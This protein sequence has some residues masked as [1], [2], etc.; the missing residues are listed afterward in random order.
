MVCKNPLKG[1]L[2]IQDYTP[3]MQGPNYGGIVNN[4]DY[5]RLTLAVCT[6]YSCY[7]VCTQKPNG[8]MLAVINKHTGALFEQS[9]AYV[10]GVKVIRGCPG[11]GAD[12]TEL[13]GQ[14]LNDSLCADVSII[15]AQSGWFGTITDPEAHVYVYPGCNPRTCSALQATVPLAGPKQ[16]PCVIM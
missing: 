9:T 14:T 10:P 1:V 6:R 7:G 16:G 3:T 2:A 8:R 5:L 4:E 15:P 13:R 12:V 11:N